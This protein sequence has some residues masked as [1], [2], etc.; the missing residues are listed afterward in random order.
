[1]V[2]LSEIQYF[3]P[4]ISYIH[5]SGA[6]NIIFD[7]YEPYQKMTFRNRTIISGANGLISLSVPLSLGRNQRGPIKEVKIANKHKW[8]S[9]HWK[10][11]LSCYNRSPWFEYYRDELVRLYEK[12]FNFLFDWDLACL[13]WSITK[14]ELPLGISIESSPNGKLERMDIIDIRNR[15][16]PNNYQETKPITYRQVFEETRGFQPNLSI[17]DLLFCEGKLASAALKGISS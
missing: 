4:V 2:L 6:S 17:L 16:R 3:A 9:S 8:Q 12:P 15:V 7:P 13:E 10:T 5:L 11:I 1:M 14:L